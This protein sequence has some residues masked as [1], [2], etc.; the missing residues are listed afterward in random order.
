MIKG[1]VYRAIPYMKA[2]M[3]CGNPLQ[4][5]GR[6]LTVVFWNLSVDHL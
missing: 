2:T 1:V 6:A 4:E 5:L 3:F